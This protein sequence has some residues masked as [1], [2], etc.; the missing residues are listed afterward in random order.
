MAQAAEDALFRAPAQE[1]RS[2]GFAG[3]LSHPYARP[4]SEISQASSRAIKKEYANLNRAYQ[5]GSKFI[6]GLDR[7]RVSVFSHP[8]RFDQWFLRFRPC[9][10]EAAAADASGNPFVGSE[11]FGWIAF[12]PGGM[13]GTK[14]ALEF[15]ENPPVFG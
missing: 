1:T 13:R 2:G 6:E 3:G 5:Q 15:P 7:R 10:H 11:I 4:S 12:S 8:D 9:G 14:K